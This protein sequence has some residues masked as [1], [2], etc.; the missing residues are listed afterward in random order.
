[1]DE[2]AAGLALGGVGSLIKL[3]APVYLLCD[4]RD[5][6]LAERVRDPHFGVS[7]IYIYDKYPGGTG[8]SES[9]SKKA[10]ELFKSAYLS[11]KNCPCKSGCPSCV[12]PG[13]N[14]KGSL[15]LLRALAE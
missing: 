15:E 3:I 14:K 9:L 10:T 1:M 5:L 7:A 12:G 11:L 8:L 6:G 2:A 4:P 13:G